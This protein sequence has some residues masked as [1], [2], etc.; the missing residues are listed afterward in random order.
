MEK[1]LFCLKLLPKK[2]NGHLLEM[3]LS[4]AVFELGFRRVESI[5]TA[6]DCGTAEVD[7]VQGHYNIF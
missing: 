7:G 2:F 4:V 5:L 6:R 1:F 3:L